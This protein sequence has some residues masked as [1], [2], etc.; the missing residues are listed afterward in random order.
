[1]TGWIFDVRFIDGEGRRVGGFTN[2][3]CTDEEAGRLAVA[4]QQPW[5]A[6][7]VV[8]SAGWVEISLKQAK[9]GEH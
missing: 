8:V 6:E 2:V 9:E 1:M 5:P 3:G 7:S 4:L